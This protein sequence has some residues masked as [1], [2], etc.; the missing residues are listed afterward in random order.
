MLIS[1][2]PTK[3]NAEHG[4]Q[5]LPALTHTVPIRP[6][7]LRTAHITQPARLLI[8]VILIAHIHPA[9]TV[10]IITVHIIPARRQIVRPACSVPV[11]TTWATRISTAPWISMLITAVQL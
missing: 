6:I 1:A 8:A 5:V 10:R 4:R 11:V 9:L 3:R 7:L 2:C